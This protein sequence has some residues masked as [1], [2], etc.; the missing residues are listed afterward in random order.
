MQ[1]CSWNTDLIYRIGKAVG[2]EVV[3][4]NITTWLAPGMNIHRNPKCGRNFEYYS[5]DPLLTGKCAAAVIKGCQS[6]GAATSA[7]HLCCNN[8]EIKRFEYDCA[9]SERAIREI[10]LKGFEIA[11]REA[12]PMALMTCYNRLNGWYVSES[13]DILTGIVRG[14]WKYDGLIISDRGSLSEPYLDILAGNNVHMPQ[15][16]AERLC[17]AIEAGYITRKQ[18]EDNF[19]R[20]LTFI[21]KLA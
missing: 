2:D 3:E 12:D 6:A 15:I 19:K 20:V 21:L 17:L 10:Y 4:N 14:E 8:K 1:A 16:N 5:E 11:V 9:V 13:Y 7:K 18:I